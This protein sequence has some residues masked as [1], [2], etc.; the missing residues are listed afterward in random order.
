MVLS[1]E[2]ALRDVE[3]AARRIADRIHRTPTLASQTLSA[4][5][6]VPVWLKAE[7][8]Q[9]TGSFKA[10]GATNAIRRLD[11]EA[12]RRGVVTISAGNHAQAV[13]YA[14]TAEGV[15]CVVVMPA[16]AVQAKVDATRAHGADVVLH[17]TTHE[18]FA[19]YEALQQ[20]QGLIPVHPFDAPDVIA[21]QG[22]VGL[23]IAEAVPDAA[24][25]IVPIGGGGLISGI[26]VALR[27]LARRTRIVGVEPRGSAAMHS[28]LSAGHPVRI[29]RLDS[30]ADGLGAPA[31]SERTLSIV[32]RLVDDVVLVSDGQ[33]VEA[34]R[35]LLER[36]KLVVEPAGAAGLAA[37]MAGAARPTGPTVVVLSGGNVDLVRL[38]AWL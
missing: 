34:M 2:P 10:R 3:D 27:G 20:E 29:E 12:R 4:M 31:V 28:A 37:L 8:L 11:A 13:A 6:G 33:I 17:G 16:N 15:R 30:I 5:A 23:E 7:N 36:M 21:G 32:G 35:L 25:V 14:A 24:T 38:K 18:A 9:K 22:T 19:R 26:A 1:P